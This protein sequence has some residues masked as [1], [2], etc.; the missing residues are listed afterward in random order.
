MD[1]AL[2]TFP[3]YDLCGL[4]HLTQWH[5]LIGLRYV[6]HLCGLHHLTKRQGLIGLRYVNHLCWP[7]PLY[8]MRSGG[9]RF[10]AVGSMG[11]G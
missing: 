11:E 5:G 9:T 6:S 4:H 10:G 1:G 8:G 7:C 3:L 2:V